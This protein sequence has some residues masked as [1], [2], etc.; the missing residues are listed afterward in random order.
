MKKHWRLFPLCLSLL[1]LSGCV[2]AANA[3]PDSTAYSL[4]FQE[5]DLA[6][7]Q[8]GD[9]LRGEPVY[10]SDSQGDS[11]VQLAEVLLEE[12]LKGP[13]DVTLKSPIPS[14]TV[15]LSLEV[16][17]SEAIVD[18][19]SPYG[20]LSGIHLT[21]ADYCIALTLTQLSGIRTVKITVRGQELAYRDHQT[22]SATDLLYSSTA[23]VVGTVDATLYFLDEAGVL[24]AEERTLELYEG[25]TQVRA[26]LKG[27]QDGPVSKDFAPPLP[28]GLLIQSV[29]QEGETCYV[30]LSSAA[31]TALQEHT[32]LD[33]AIQAMA[34]SLCSL[35]TVQEVQ[36]LV[37]GEF[38]GNY[39]SL[40]IAQP[41]HWG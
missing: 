20:T 22:F 13:L 17:G 10:L 41:Y 19:S 5:T 6:Q 36:Y 1:L 29:W 26:V 27:L 38:T 30:N 4:Y 11:A 3:K 23:D 31:L 35:K 40:S 32:A 24:A 9:A 14:G 7:A 34:R 8:G 2:Y 28:E 18:L 39:G 21:M 16:K 25:D 15:L 33:M 12:L 37:D